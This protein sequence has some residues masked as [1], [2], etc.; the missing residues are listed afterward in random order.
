MGMLMLVAP[1]QFNWPA[2]A[3][4]QAQLTWWGLGFLAAGIGLLAVVILAPRFGLVVLAHVWA[5]ALL[6]VLATGFVQIGGWGAAFAYL[7]LGL[8]AA[9]PLVGRLDVRRTWLHAD[10]LSLLL[11]LGALLSGVVL[12]ANPGS[13]AAS[14]YDLARPFFGWFGL[15]FCASAVVV[16]VSQTGRRVPAWARRA[17]PV[18]LGGVLLVFGVITAIPNHDWTLFYGGFGAALIGLSMLGARLQR[19]DPASLRT[20][21]ALV[22]GAAVAVPLIGLVSIFA[23]NQESMAVAEQ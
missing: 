18:L 11:A 12:L 10:A 21:L 16:G 7:A 8:A 13:F 6:L 14:R 15:A 19:L 20:R 5:G 17:A 9:D 3:L 23:H 4:L 22:L 1:H 2:F